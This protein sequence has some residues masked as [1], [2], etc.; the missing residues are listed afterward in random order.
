MEAFN[1]RGPA[2]SDHQNRIT[3]IL[4]TIFGIVVLTFAASDAA[5]AKDRYTTDFNNYYGTYGTVRGTTMGSCITC[6]VNPDG[7]GGVNPYGNHWKSYGN[8]FAAVEPLDSDGDGFSNI[9]EIIADTWPGDAGSQP[10]PSTSP[11]LADAG[12]DRNVQEGALVMLDG[13]NSMDPDGDIASYL[14]EQTAGTP[15][16]LSNPA[17]VQPS[18]TAPDV[19][20]GGESLVFRLTVTDSEGQQGTD[21]CIVNISAINHP[22]VANAGPDQTVSEGVTVTL[23]GSNSSDADNDIATYQWEQT[24][25]TP[26]T[27]SNAAAVQPT[28]TAPNVGTGGESLTFRLTVTDSAGLQDTDTSLVNI[29]WVNIAPTAS[30]GSDQ[31]VDEGEVVALSGLGSSDPDDGIVAFAWLQ[32][33]GI[34]VTLS[35][36]AAVQPTFTAPDV[37]P[38][39]A[40]LTF[41]LTVIDSGG[42]KG[43]DTCIVNISWVNLPPTADAGPDQTVEVGVTVTLDGSN[44]LDQDDGIGSY[45]W[46]QTGGPPVTLSDPAASRPTFLAP[47]VGAG[48]ASLTFSLTVTDQFGLQNSDTCVVNVSFDNTPPTADAGGDQL[49]N[50]SLPVTLDGSNSSD[51]DGTIAAYLWTQTGGTP[52]TLSDPS[53]ARPVFT[54]PD[55]GPAGQALTFQLQVTDDGGLQDTD[56]CIVNVSWVNLPPTADAGPDQTVSEG[57]TVTLD[58]SNSDDLDDGI[59][60]YQWTQTGGTPVTLSNPST[61]IPLFTAPLV[62][63]GGDSLTF[64]LTVTDSDGLQDTD[65]CI[66][67][68]SWVNLPPTADAGVDQTVNQGATVAL[69][70]SAST[71]PDGGIAD[72]LWTQTAG[73]AVTLSDPSAAQPT[74]TAPNVGPG[75]GSLTFKLTVNDSGGLQA[76]DTVNINVTWQNQ[77]P[78]ADAGPD[79]T[80]LEGTTITLD[81]SGSADQDDG[82]ISYAWVQTGSGPAAT[83]S[84]PTAIQPTF[85]APAVDQNGATLVFEVTVR[86][87]GGLQSSQAVTIN[88]TDN[89]ISGFPPEAITMESA[90]GNPIAVLEGGGGSITSISHMDPSSLPAV[91]KMPQ[92]MIFGLLDL[93]IK[94]DTPG[95]TVTVTIFLPQPAPEGYKWYKF[96]PRTN[97]W[98]DYT[99]VTDTGGAK[100]AVFN[101]TRDQVT[102]TLVDG[103]IGDD[104]GIRNGVIEDPSGLGA[105]ITSLGSIGSNSFGAG[106]GSCFIGASAVG[107]RPGPQ[108][109]P[110]VSGLAAA[111]AVFF[112]TR[113]LIRLLK[114]KGTGRTIA[115]RHKESHR[116]DSNKKHLNYG[117]QK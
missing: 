37:G 17:A 10:A 19:A 83:L 108:R 16:A 77:P 22:P 113:A 32:L 94:P 103:G 64:Q 109:I 67:N 75:G 52:V 86:D 42:L 50:E 28:F 80:A 55:V 57:S 79:Q 89:G 107:R 105:G 117:F 29:S 30:A 35:N 24:T 43:T 73:P 47:D 110:V 34:P 59:A 100:G 88:V 106:G 3:K 62:G 31:T 38:G 91:E 66:V 63:A 54:A 33:T 74:F 76:S 6:H 58:G 5:H 81:A 60:S 85:V 104:D 84:D 36:P 65:T 49:V 41:Q 96:N 69:D 116:K 51:T 14:W 26:V 114:L 71:D 102:L 90:Q 7:K 101:D 1:L 87:G 40:A 18:F 23:D 12:P 39:G 111:L 53:A 99:A 72:Y 45:L 112:S 13:S 70:G 9:D 61:V 68:I 20:A 97:V 15:V 2:C 78:A 93:Q 8:N 46:T 56:T 44:S 11:P 21:T 95:A 4:L 25:G 115:D 92:D 82:I 98:T 48:G 27:L